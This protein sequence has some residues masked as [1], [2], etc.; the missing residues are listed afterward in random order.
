MKENILK[1]VAFCKRELDFSKG[2]YTDPY[3]SI[4]PCILDCVYS[5]RAKYFSITRPTVERYAA[6]YMG[7]DP[8]A[9]GYTMDD[10]IH[11]IAA[12]GGARPFARDV[13]RN[14]QVLSGRLKSEVCLDVA[15]KLA[16][17]GIQTIDDFVAEEES[18]T[19]PMLRSVKGMGNAAISFFYMLTGDPDKCKPDTH[20]H[21]AVR[22]ALGRDLSDDDCQKLF[23]GSVEILKAD[24]P[25][26]TVAYLDSLVWQKYS[27]M[28]RR[29]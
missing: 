19:E 12:S 15:E 2:H 6:K 26:L 27:A 1:M 5:L 13:L 29:K 21:H 20:I 3:M 16:Q 9:P 7:G 10:F 24:Y 22:D 4:G 8:F 14:N 11:H 18:V 25:K 28:K 23:M 17:A